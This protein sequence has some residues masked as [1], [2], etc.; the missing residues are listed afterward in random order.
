MANP[1]ARLSVQIGFPS[2]LLWSAIISPGEFLYWGAIICAVVWAKKSFWTNCKDELL[3]KLEEH[4]YDPKALR[5]ICL[6]LALATLSLCF[7]VDGMHSIIFLS[8]FFAPLLLVPAVLIIS[9][10][11][12]RF[13]LRTGSNRQARIL[14]KFWYD[15]TI[16]GFLVSFLLVLSCIFFSPN[17]LGDWLANWLNFSATSANMGPKATLIWYEA[18]AQ[19]NPPPNWRTPRAMENVDGS[20]LPMSFDF[21]LAMQAFSF[22]LCSFFFRSHIIRWSVYLTTF[23]RRLTLSS[24][25]SVW[26]ASF[27][28]VHRQPVKKLVVKEAVPLLHNVSKTFW[29]LTGCYLALFALVAFCPGPVGVAILNWIQFALRD[30]GFTHLSIFDHPQLRL[31]FAA[32]VAMIG[33]GPLA[34]TAC[35]F[36][37]NLKPTELILSSEGL[38]TPSDQFQLWS[39]VKSV[40]VAPLGKKTPWLK[41][42][43][44]VS[45]FKGPRLRLKHSQL[46]KQDLCELLSAIDEHAQSCSFSEEA[47]E[48]RRNLGNENN[49]VPEQSQFR[50]L[51]AEDFRST[52]FVPIRAGECIADKNIRVIRQL[53]SKQLSAVYLVRMPDGQLAITKQFCFPTDSEDSA[54]LLKIFQREYEL[55]SKLDHPRIAKVLDVFQEEASSY[56]ILEFSKG[57]DL[58]DIV[59]KDGARS[60]GVALEIA[61]QLCDAML[62]LHGQAI[63]ILHRDLTPDN[64]IVDEDRQ[65]RLIDF[66]AAH[67]FLEGITGTLIGKQCYVAPEQLR[68]EASPS[69]DIYSFGCT[70]H[71]LL[72]GE[73]PIALSQCDPSLLTNV[74]AA[75]RTLIMACTEFDQ[76]NRPRSFQEIR[77]ELLHNKRGGSIRVSPDKQPVPLQKQE[78]GV[79]K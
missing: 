50:G 28:E 77:E 56:L 1:P 67:Q 19:A 55:L 45:F 22:I 25:L 8:R 15:L 48:I 60:E 36:L 44:V 66:G 29:W 17:G 39:D 7:R 30:A 78:S 32:I 64:I 20:A 24:P 68:G 74:S 14:K 26:I 52:V 57:R 70:L 16:A 38:L 76:E 33:A 31:F 53:A 27:L 2:A 34:V 62:H 58:R 42:T 47:L 79:A 65:I 72:T 9:V 5:F 43:L 54:R 23:A 75:M 6:A 71:F 10:A 59:E 41:Q 21:A 18:D 3:N 35:V 61:E 49:T 73:D 37:P 11:S 46:S 4:F 63:P 13:L 40:E 12:K 51:P 69:S